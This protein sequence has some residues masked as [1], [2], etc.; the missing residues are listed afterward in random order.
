MRNPRWSREFQISV[1]LCEVTRAT[2]AVANREGGIEGIR[3][4]GIVRPIL[5]DLSVNLFT[6][7]QLRRRLIASNN[8]GERH[9]RLIGK[10][11]YT[12]KVADGKDRL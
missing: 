1:A 7:Y 12:I 11:L 3:L 6:M 4:A 8:A 5:I 10:S 9:N 2:P